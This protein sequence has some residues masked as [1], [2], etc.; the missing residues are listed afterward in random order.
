MR[1]QW[2]PWAAVLAA[3]AVGTTA[4]GM[5]AV[6]SLAGRVHPIVITLGTLS[7]YRGLTLLLI[8]ARAIYSEDVPDA[9]RDPWRAVLLGL[10]APVWMAAGIIVLAWLML[11]Q[12]VAGRSALALG[13]NPVVAQRA[14][15]QRW[16]VW[17]VVF[18]LQGLLAALAGMQSLAAT[19]NLQATDFEEMTLEAISVAVIGGVAITG[20]RAP[21]WG[22]VAAAVLFRL[23]AK[24]WVLLHIDSY[25][26]HAIVGGMLLLA[27]LADRL[28][29]CAR[30]DDG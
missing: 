10:P 17:I 18:A 26:Q 3:L 23:L 11:G 19:A 12:T 25:W 30:G 9:F 15:I 4:G 6:L 29:R 7:L 8:G 5:N 2:P 14:G 28:W 20:G 16:R 27:I 13:S 24:G 21:L 1:E 22:V